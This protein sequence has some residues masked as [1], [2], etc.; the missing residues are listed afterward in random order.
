MCPLYLPSDSGLWGTML[1]KCK[2]D[3]NKHWYPQARCNTSAMYEKCTAVFQ[4]VLM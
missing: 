4:Y 3:G 1:V 2:R